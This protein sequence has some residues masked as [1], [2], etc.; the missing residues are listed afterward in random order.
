MSKKKTALLN[1]DNNYWPGFVK[2]GLLTLMVSGLGASLAQAQAATADTCG[3]SITSGTQVERPNGYRAWVE[4]QNIDGEAATDFEVLLDLG[5]ATITQGQQAEF[6]SVENGYW[7]TAPSNLAN[8]TI[9]PNRSHRFQFN[10]TLPHEGV[11]PYLISINGMPCDLEPPQVTLN[12]SDRLM[13]DSGTL[14]LTAHAQDNVGIRYVEFKK[15]GQVIATDWQAPYQLELD[16]SD[17]ANGLNLYTATAYDP[18]GNSANSKPERV[19]VAIGN[20]YFGTAPGGPSTYEHLL[21]YFNQLTPENAGKWGSVAGQRGVMDWSG[22]DTAYQ[23]ARDNQIPFRYHNL[24]WGEQQPEWLDSL[25]SAEQL[26]EVDNWMRQVAQRYPDLELVEVVNEPLHA[27]P[28]YIEALG[29]SGATGWD[30]VI[31][32][33]EM[34]REH[35]PKAQLTLND[36]QILHLP[37]FTQ[38]YLE[39]INL[40]HERNLIDAISVQGHFL[41]RADVT[42]VATNLDSLAATGLPIYVSEFDLNFADDARHAN[43]FRDLFSVF[44]EH[45]SVVGVTHWGHLEGTV[46]RPNAYL[47]RQDGT[48]RPALEWVICY[49]EGGSNCYVPE[50]VPTGWQGNDYGLS[51]EAEEFDAGEGVLAVGDVVAYTDDGDW[52]AYHDV[53]FQ[54]SWD[55]FSISYAKGNQSVGNI[56]IHLGSLDSYPVLTLDLPPTAGWGSVETLEVPWN[57]LMGTYDV[58]IRFNNG[59]GIA[60]VDSLAFGRPQDEPA[61]FINLVNDGGFEGSSLVGWQAWN[62]ASLSL[63]SQQAYAGNQSL[64]AS[65]RPD[66]NQFAVYDL[67]SAVRPGT[68]Y[69]VSAQAFIDGSAPDTIRMAAMVQC[70]DSPEGHNSFPWLHNRTNVAPG[71]WTEL[72]ANLVIPDCNLQGVAIFFEG[73]SAG[74]DVYLDE[75]R[76]IP[77]AASPNLIADGSFESGFAGWSAWNGSTLSLSSE[78]AFTGS[79]SLYITDR[80]NTAQYAVY[81]LTASVTPGTTYTVSAQ[82]LIG[83]SANDTVRLAAKV[84]CANPPDGHNSFPWLQNNSNVT[85]GV[86][87]E[88]SADLVIPDCDLVD[89]AIFLEGTSAGIDVYLDEVS[90]TAN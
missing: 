89:V 18:S 80:P 62:G 39:I 33:F 2:A 36:Y 47:V 82:A 81:N 16:I 26:A 53:E 11:T 15:N 77:P 8:K 61:P 85:P 6:E 30:W 74:V 54:G 67:S 79:Q 4:L 24:V 40:L 83:G 27:P 71:Q 12:A 78:Q 57:P 19:F 38:E 90:V 21:T 17:A 23:F 13:V 65:N 34:A 51:L 1:R 5:A 14:V 25:S 58:Y 43:V 52:I 29:G 42:L 68:T 22:V 63:S 9:R 45:P 28:G 20:R 35:F 3:Y 46:W 69:T 64:L 75:V 86:W 10:A 41:E 59:W 73:T 84:E 87:T 70:S 31:T 60:N 49:I 44:W 37:E 48:P 72:S 7:V 55:V 50:Y 32:A 76:V 88:I 56:S 66:A